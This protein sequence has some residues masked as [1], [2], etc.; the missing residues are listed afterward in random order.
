MKA[1][2]WLG[3]FNAD[4][5]KLAITIPTKES[6]TEDMEEA[7]KSYANCTVDELRSHMTERAS[8][9][10]KRGAAGRQARSAGAKK[11]RSDAP[12]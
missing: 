1:P 7:M 11:M 3:Q 5:D 9:T 10:E 12:E 2:E 8:R 6:V 4:E